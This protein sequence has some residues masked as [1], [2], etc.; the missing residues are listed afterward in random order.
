MN[1]DLQ[2]HRKSYDKGELK[3]NLVDDNPFNQF[4]QW[5]AVAENSETVEEA[6]AMTL[7]TSNTSGMPRGRVVL[8]KEV[9]E[10]G[11]IF[12]TNYKSE[13]GKAIAANNKVCISFFWPGLERQ[14]LIMGTAHKIS[15]EKSAAYFSQ[16][17]RKSQLGALVSD[18]SQVIASRVALEEKLKDLVLQFEGK[19]IPKPADWGGYLIEPY[20]FEFWQGRQSRLHDRIEYKKDNGQWA[21][22]RLQ[23]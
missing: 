22:I 4:E 18:Q 20:S 6:N 21:K 14:I 17:P 15:E 1:K 8:L 12:Y 3:D 11:F 23:P 7:S 19:E 5:F 9:T 13:K 16:R 2:A 10:D